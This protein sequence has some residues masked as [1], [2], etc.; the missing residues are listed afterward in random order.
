MKRWNERQALNF[1]L[2]I[3]DADL[4][5]DSYYPLDKCFKLYERKGECYLKLALSAR[6]IELKE[7]LIK[8]SI[9][10]YEY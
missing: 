8:K 7:D 4:A 3:D 1:Q 9:T 5:L 6:T 10:S 2:A